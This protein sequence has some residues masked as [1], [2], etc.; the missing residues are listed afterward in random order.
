MALFNRKK[1]AEPAPAP[2][3]PSFTLTVP[4]TKNYRGFKRI[5]LAT[6]KDPYAEAGIKFVKGS[7]IKGITFEEYLYENTSPLMRVYADGNQIGTIWSS[8]W[9]EY[10]DMIRSGHCTKASVS[11][12]DSG[13]VML[14]VKFE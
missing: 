6:Y 13:D 11:F 5:K 12:A 2:V 10:F 14:F 3:Q 7:E 1:K 8:S 9:Q 4:H